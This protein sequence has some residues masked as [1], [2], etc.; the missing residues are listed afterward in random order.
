MGR[1]VSRVHGKLPLREI[2]AATQVP[3]SGAR[4]RGACH[5]ATSIDERKD[6]GHR[7]E[8]ACRS[9][10]TNI[11]LSFAA[12]GHRF[13]VGTE[14]LRRVAESLPPQCHMPKNMRSAAAP[15]ALLAAASGA[16]SMIGVAAVARTNA[17]STKGIEGS[18]P[19]RRIARRLDRQ[20]ANV[21]TAMAG[22]ELMADKAPHIPARINPGPLFAR[23]A[24]GAVVGASVARMEGLDRRS[25]AI[26]GAVVSFAAAHASYRLRALLAKRVPGFVAGLLED[27]LIVGVAVAGAALLPSSAS[28]RNTPRRTREPMVLGVARK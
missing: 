26:G 2:A 1:T 17:L 12:H 3:P 15:I 5:P 20:I 27:V 18:A 9:A 10:E 25:A 21:A 7:W 28:L 6:I 24:A 4:D 22:F 11:P 16:R 13:L 14:L 8:L 19:V 23:V